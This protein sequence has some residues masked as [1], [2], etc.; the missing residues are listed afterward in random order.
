M[1]GGTVQRSLLR[2]RVLVE[3]AM[4]MLATCSLSIGIVILSQSEGKIT[5]D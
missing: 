5:V 4:R 1:I 2:I 3:A